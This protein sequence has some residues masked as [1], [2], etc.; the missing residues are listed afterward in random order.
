MTSSNGYTKLPPGKIANSV[1]WLELT[2]LSPR[3][4]AA[5]VGFSLRQL[6]SQDA[7]LHR[8]LYRAVGTPWLWAGL[9]SKSEAD[10]AAYLAREDI[11]SFVAFDGDTPV[12][13]LDLDAAQK[14]ATETGVEVSYFGFIPSHT[15]KGAGAWLMAEAVRITAENGANRLWLHSCNF[16][17]PGAVAFYARQ[18]FRIYA[19]GFEIMDDPRHVGLMPKDAAQH[20]PMMVF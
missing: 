2:D 7:A 10:I 3:D 4:I 18:G 1:T 9:I 20:V 5:P 12:A 16:D 14:D 8:K 15:G 17:H 13:L 6:S 19:Q 11:L